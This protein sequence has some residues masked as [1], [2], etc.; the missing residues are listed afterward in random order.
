VQEIKAI[1]EG[2]DM[3]RTTQA[4]DAETAITIIIATFA[5]LLIFAIAG[6]SI[7]KSI[8]THRDETFTV[9]KSERITESN[10]SSRYL[11]YTEQGVYENT[12]SLL[13]GKFTSSDLYNELAAGRTY[14]CD[15]IGWRAP[16][17][18][19]YPN[20]ISCDGK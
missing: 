1:I 16:F 13:N 14:T 5:V 8:A 3:K 18:S 15:V 17:L 7:Y 2:G 11:I 6:I 12:D 9:K 19:W 20:I 4:G 10:N